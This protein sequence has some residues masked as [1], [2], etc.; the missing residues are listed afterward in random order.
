MSQLRSCEQTVTEHTNVGDTVL[1]QKLNNHGDWD[2]CLKTG[3][4]EMSGNYRPV[5]LTSILEKVVEH[6]ACLDFSKTFDIVIGMSDWYQRGSYCHGLT[7][8][9]CST[10]GSA[11]SWAG[12]EQQ[13]AAIYAGSAQWKAAWWKWSW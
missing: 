9:S 10:R 11:K 7:G 1:H 13:P 2:K 6:T 8:T 5:N 12:K 3:G 4:K